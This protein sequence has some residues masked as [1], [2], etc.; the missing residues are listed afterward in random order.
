AAPRVLDPVPAPPHSQQ[1]RSLV[2]AHG[3]GALCTL[4]PDGSP[5]GSITQYVLDD[6]GR[7]VLLLSTIAEHTRNLQ[8]DPRA[9]LLVGAS[10]APGDDPMAVARVTLVGSARSI[11]ASD[12]PELTERYLTRHPA[13]RSY[14]DFGDFGWWRIEVD[15]VRFVGGYGRMS[16]VDPE[17]YAT[18]TAHPLAE[19]ADRIIAHMN[20]DHADAALAYVQML[21]GVPEATSARVVAVDRLGLELV[22]TTP[23]GVQPARV[24]FDEPADTP[25]AVRKAVVTL[26]ARARGT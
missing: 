19:H 25:D 4:R 16:W 10:V 24:N 7:P 2:H 13:A 11:A 20:D 17:E 23:T 26:L 22:A 8:R 9:S 3:I 6:R 5:F 18:M 14:V 12:H 15:S 1:A 21:C